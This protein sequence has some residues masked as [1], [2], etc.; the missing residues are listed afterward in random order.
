MTNLKQSENSHGASKLIKIAATIF[1][2]VILTAPMFVFAQ[3]Q[4]PLGDLGSNPI[5]T[6]IKK[7]LGYIVTIGGVVA[8]FMFIWSGFLYVK[9]QGN[10]TELE[11]AKGVFINTC[12]G[13]ALLLGADLIGTVITNTI[14]SLKS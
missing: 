14:G 5:P 12:I 13:T 7:I 4:N 8:T 9:A 3:I 10:P 2:L 6:L 11:K 1:S